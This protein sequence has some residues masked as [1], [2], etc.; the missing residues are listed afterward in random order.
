MSDDKKNLFSEFPPV[1]TATWEAKIIAD[2]KGADYDKKLVWKTLEGF[3]V[4]PY[5]RAEN[6]ESLSYL[7]QLPGVFPFVR[8]KNVTGNEWLVR[9]DITVGD[10]AEA[11]KKA[12]QILQKGI[13]SL[14]FVISKKAELSKEYMKALLKNICLSAVEINFVCGKKSIE[15]IPFFIEYVQNEGYDP[16]SINGSVTLDTVGHLVKSGTFCIGDNQQAVAAISKLITQLKPYPGFQAITIHGSYFTN[17][18]SSITQSLA[19]TLAIGADYLTWLTDVGL[20]VSD[21]AGKLKFNFAV[22]SNYFMEIAKFRAARF[23][24]AKIAESYDGKCKVAMNIHAETSKWNKTAYDP[25]VNVLRATTEAMSAAIG[26]VDSMTVIPFDVT[27][28]ASSEIAE[29]IARNTQIILQEEAYLKK[30]VDPSAGSYY[31]E[32]LTD[33]LVT[34]AWKLFLTIQEKGGFVNAFKEGFIQSQVKEVAQKRENAVATRREILLGTNQFP[35]FNEILN[36]ELD[37]T[38]YSCGCKSGSCN[39][40]QKERIAEPLRLFRGSQAFEDLRQ[41]TD[42]SGRRPKVFMVTMGSVAMRKARATFA[43]N[44]FACAGFEVV[45]NNGFKTADEGVKAALEAKADIVVIC[46]SDDEYVLLAP[47]VFEKLGGKAL[48][49]VAGAPTCEEELKTKGIKN[50]ISVKSNVLETLKYYQKEL[51]LI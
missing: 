47:E 39:N 43:C 44:F 28:E 46:S 38:S 30:I 1:S 33:S 17:A 2:L 26:I 12:L 51:H 27:F 48:F 49:V 16:A 34:E 40:D 6:L 4:K 25:Y 3:N 24:W 29:R 36:K 11:N 31:I 21:V 23:L 15:L 45:D 5:Y 19:F 50:F 22:S 42:K 32:S 9:Q 13:T 14:G 8:G 10:P 37:D 20:P 41:T 7:K 35:N 18:G